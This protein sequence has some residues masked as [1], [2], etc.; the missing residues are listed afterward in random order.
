MARSA[1]TKKQLNELAVQTSRLLL[2]RAN[3]RLRLNCGFVCFVVA[4]GVNL[5]AVGPAPTKTTVWFLDGFYLFGC[6]FDCESFIR[7]RWRGFDDQWRV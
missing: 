6:L 4:A 1:T 7:D 2:C 5:N 3:Y